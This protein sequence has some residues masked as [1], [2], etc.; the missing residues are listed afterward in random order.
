MALQLL[1][2]PAISLAQ[3]HG[4]D[5]PG[6]P[7]AHGPPGSPVVRDAPAAA[8]DPALGTALPDVVRTLEHH[9]DALFADYACTPDGWSETQAARRVL[10]ALNLQLF[11]R[12]S[13]GEAAPS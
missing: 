5:L 9:L 12:R 6:R 7:P 8:G 1:E 4:L 13:A 10:A 3:G 11:K 2:H